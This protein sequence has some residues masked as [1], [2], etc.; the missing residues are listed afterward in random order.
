MFAT[1]EH[2]SSKFFRG[3][4]MDGRLSLRLILIVC[5]V[6]VGFSLTAKAYLFW[7]AKWNVSS[8]TYYVNPSNLDLSNS[9]AITGVQGA[10]NVW[11]TQGQANM[12]LAYGGTSN[13][14]ANGND[15]Q[16]VVFFRNSNPDG[17]SACALAEAR[18]WQWGETIV[19]VDIILWENTPCYSHYWTIASR[20]CNPQGGE[21]GLYIEDVIAH[22]FGHLLGLDHSYEGTT[23]VAGYPSCSTDPR[24]LEAD[25]ISGLQ[26][27][28]GVSNGKPDPTP[29]PTVAP[30]PAPTPEPSG[31]SLSAR[32]Y[33]VKG[34][35]RADL[36]W[37]GATTSTVNVYRNGV[38][39]LTTPNDGTQTD[40]I[41]SKGGGTYRYI[42]CESGGSICSN[43]VTASF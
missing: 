22:E 42:L 32:G 4:D 7:G 20:G 17:K 28:Y 30:T 39:I 1:Q 11:N 8:V 9:D 2:Y 33:K 41:N 29:V 40:V 43:E 37:G 38:L 18:S 10:A 3:E 6:V 5:L 27:L 24:T 34:R 12:K 19:D 14:N 16:N 26:A 23:M 13:V 35:T 36:T 25:D 15:G 31:L 21:Y